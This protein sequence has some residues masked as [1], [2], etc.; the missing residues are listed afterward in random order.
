MPPMI[1][2]IFSMMISSFV[3]LFVG[4]IEETHG[5]ESEMIL[6]SFI[7]LELHEFESRWTYENH[8]IFFK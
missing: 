2:A 1:S 6:A 3:L 5:T 7:L 4:F 8:N